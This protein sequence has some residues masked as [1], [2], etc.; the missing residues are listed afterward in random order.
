MSHGLDP[1][2]KDLLHALNLSQPPLTAKLA[3]G[4]GNKGGHRRG[5]ATGSG[6]QGLQG[7]SFTPGDPDQPVG[8]Q[9][10][11]LLSHGDTAAGILEPQEVG[12]PGQMSQDLGPVLFLAGRKVVTRHRRQHH[13]DVDRSGHL[14]EIPNGALVVSGN[15]VPVG[16]GKQE[17]GIGSGFLGVAGHDSGHSVAAASPHHHRQLALGP[18]GRSLRHGAML[19]Q[20]QREDLPHA[21]PDHDGHV[22]NPGIGVAGD[23]A[24]KALGVQAAVGMKGSDHEAVNA[25][26]T[27]PQAV[28][29]GAA[30]GPR[31]GQSGDRGFHRH[32]PGHQAHLPEKCSAAGAAHRQVSFILSFRS[33]VGSMLPPQAQGAQCRAG[34]AIAMIQEMEC[35]DE[36]L[37][38]IRRMRQVPPITPASGMMA[39][40]GAPGSCRILDD[41]RNPPK[42]EEA[43]AAIQH[44]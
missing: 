30:R 41:K 19:F 18:P 28:H 21:A 40:A 2:P 42:P 37:G 27:L 26:D 43:Y 16:R 23:V 31:P 36:F 10:P 7:V 14:G 1:C 9:S 15:P 5:I 24:A 35:D 17:D 34:S 4:F 3:A 13:A 44:L 29:A 33:D 22:P 20:I 8:N 32:C 12:K 6:R 25:L 39:A 11:Q 38:E